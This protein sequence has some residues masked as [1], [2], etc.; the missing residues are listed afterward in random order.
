MNHF[1]DMPLEQLQKDLQ[2]LGQKPYRATQIIQWVYQRGTCDFAAMSD[3]P[4]LLRVELAGKYTILT[5]HIAARTDTADDVTK[6]LIQ[7]PDGQRVE[8]VAIPTGPR[9]TVCV[10]TQVGCA[11]ECTF[12]ASG[13]G[14]LVRNLTA[15]EII[16]QI[17]HLRMAV[18]RKI[19]H[20][21]FMGMGEPLANYDA[22]IAAVHAIIDPK[23]LALSAR[24][25]TIS[26]VGLPKGIRRLAAENLPVGLAISL[27]APTDALRRQIM[28]KAATVDI[29]D[30]VA[31]AQAFYRARHREITLE[32]VLLA[33]VN[34]TN[35]C[36]EALARI[37]HQ[38]RCNVNLIRYNPVEEV[39]YSPPS[40]GAVRMFAQRLERRSVNVQIRNSRGGEGSAAC[41]QLRQ[42]ASQE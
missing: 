6:L 8:C 29:E 3:L 13:R 38:L 35:V 16:E 15:G 20:V 27:H 23:R 18:G 9:C 25:V 19:T 33:G 2:A 41:G 7:W 24:H 4:E 42:D 32:Y 30:L 37:A 5:G 31:A 36:A 11:M 40:M 28:P 34:D 12:C 22:T 1:L 21:V 17:L 10:S 14:G 39:P 26:T